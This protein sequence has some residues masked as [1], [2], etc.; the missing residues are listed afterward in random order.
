MF[1]MNKKDYLDYTTLGILN[2]LQI[3]NTGYVSLGRNLNVSNAALSARLRKLQD[4]GYITHVTQQEACGW[5]AV[6][7]LTESGKRLV[8]QLAIPDFVK[9]VEK[10]TS[11][12]I[13][14]L[15]QPA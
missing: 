7:A 9:K 6:F 3:T 15:P 12:K 5:R 2:Q 1:S 13:T 14:P 11:A 10:I 4:A 8:E